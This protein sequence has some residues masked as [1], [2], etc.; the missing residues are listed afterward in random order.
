MCG[1]SGKE[2]P[3][4][5]LHTVELLTPNNFA[6]CFC[7]SRALFLAALKLILS[8]CFFSLPIRLNRICDDVILPRV[9]KRFKNIYLIFRKPIHFK[10]IL[11]YNVVQK[12][13]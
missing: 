2:T 1:A 13:R 10:R 3:F 8:T 9:C 6:I 7:V 4:S 12:G 11:V 5:Q